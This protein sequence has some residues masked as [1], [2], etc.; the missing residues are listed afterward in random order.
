MRHL[1]RADD[2]R[3]HARA[4]EHPR[5]PD[6]GHFHPASL[7]HRFD[8]VDHVPVGG[9]VVQQ[10][11]IVVAARARGRAA[12]CVP[13]GRRWPR[14]DA[15]GKRTPGDQPYAFVHAQGNHLSLLFAIE[16]VVVVLHGD[17]SRPAFAFRRGQCLRHP[18]RGTGARADVAN[19]SGADQVVQ[20]L[21]RLV[22]GDVRIEPVDLIEVDGVEAEAPEARLAGLQ[23]VLARQPASV[24][25]VAHRVEDFRGDHDFIAMRELLDRAARDFLAS[26]QRVHVRRI[27]EVD[28]RFDRPLKEGLGRLFVEY[29]R[30][31]CGIAVAHATERETR[32]VEATSAEPNVLHPVTLPRTRDV[33]PGVTYELECRTTDPKF[34]AWPTDPGGVPNPLN[35]P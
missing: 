14:E 20:R 24:R 11:R 10:V 16:E 5:K 3:G 19:F 2:R 29:P 21:E 27:E 8:G 35:Q 23:D 32:H 17:E 34:P 7:R 25:A 1:R 6:F 31:P 15:A 12:A 33:S 9:A 26:S 18:P 28:S 13:F 22:D 30:A 4:A